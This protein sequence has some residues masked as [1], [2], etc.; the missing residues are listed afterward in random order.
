MNISNKIKNRGMTMIE[1][2]VSVGILAL[3]MVAVSS[4]QVSVLRNNKYANDSLQSA[5]DAR[6]ILKTIVKELR[7]AKPG[8]NGSY[9]I[10]QA[11]TSSITFYSDTDADG[12]Q[13]QIRY[14]LLSN[15]L[16][17]GSIKPT[18][19]P[20]IY[21]SANETFKILA[22]SVKNTASSSLFEYYN[23]VYATT[24][25]ALTQPVTTSAVRLVKVNLLIDADP[26]RSP[27]PR[28]YVGQVTL[29]NL[30]DNL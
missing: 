11:A 28:L 1:I 29:R 15:T 2:V 19:S 4:F 5:Q 21:N 7:S 8:N 24:S 13:E 22:S 23:N 14:F 20:L 3:I 30:K 6:A 9:P 27:V 10:S 12:L 17:R 26:N 16:K 18:G 25:V